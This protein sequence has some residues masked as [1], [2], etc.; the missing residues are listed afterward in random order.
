MEIESEVKPCQTNVIF[1]CNSGRQ[2]EGILCGFTW[3]SKSSAGA[4][5]LHGNR[6]PQRLKPLKVS[7]TDRVSCNRITSF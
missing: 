2:V 3:T 7:E 4:L 6:P 1:N 5:L